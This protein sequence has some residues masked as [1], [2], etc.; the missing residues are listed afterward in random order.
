MTNIMLMYIVPPR[1]VMCATPGRSTEF[2]FG[3][4]LAISDLRVL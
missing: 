4:E 3:A 1:G 2:G